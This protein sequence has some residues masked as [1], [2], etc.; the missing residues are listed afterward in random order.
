MTTETSPATTEG[1]LS[2]AGVRALKI[3]IV[4]MGVMIVLGLVAVVAR[5][6]YLAGQSPSQ[7]TVSVVPAAGLA[8]ARIALPA[9]A[10]VRHLAI[11]GPRVAVHY[12]TTSGPGLAVFD[13]STGKP[14]ARLA[15]DP[16]P[17]RR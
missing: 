3:A 10:V 8:E 12:E 4:V 13:W 6:I 5:I 15:I 7:A 9:G 2:P 17:P 14:L 1:P 11:D 16:E